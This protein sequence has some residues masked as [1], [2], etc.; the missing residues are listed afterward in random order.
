[1]AQIVPGQRPSEACLRRARRE[2]TGDCTRKQSHS[3]GTHMNLG[4]LALRGVVGPLFVGHGTQKLFGWFGGHGLEGTAGFFEQGIGL[5]PGKRHATA[6]GVSEA[7]GGALL[8]L[9]AFTPAAAGMVI[10]TMTTA[11]RKVHAPKGPWVTEGGYEYNAVIIAAMVALAESGPGTPSVDAALFPRMKGTGWALLAL[12][13]GAAG[14]YLATEDFNE[15]PPPAPATVTE[16]EPRFARDE[17]P[18]E[19]EPRFERE[20]APSA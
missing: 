19:S 8:T 2:H 18:A 11:T 5:R 10:G 3:R 9:G 1:M 17:V 6:A 7:L 16:D 14:S 20:Q 4:K 12:A 13:A 15:P